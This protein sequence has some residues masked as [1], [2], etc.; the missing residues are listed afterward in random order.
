MSTPGGGRCVRGGRFSLPKM[1][2]RASD[3]DLY[4]SV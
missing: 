3:F 1:N 2:G 4:Q